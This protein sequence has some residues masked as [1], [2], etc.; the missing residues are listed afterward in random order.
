MRVSTYDFLK[1][2]GVELGGA[3]FFWVHR[4]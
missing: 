4:Y 1:C 3:N 2:V